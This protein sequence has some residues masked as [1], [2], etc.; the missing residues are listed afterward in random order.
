MNGSAFFRGMCSRARSAD[1]DRGQAAR[2]DD[3]VD[4]LGAE[5]RHAQQLLAAG[6]CDIEREAVAVA[7]RPG[8]FRI[9]VERQHAFGLVDDLAGVKTVKPHQPV[10]LVE[11]VLANAAAAATSGSARLASGIGLKAE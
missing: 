3:A 5:A 7:Q 1:A 6:G 11:P 9:D 8:Q 10:G 2:G 4:R